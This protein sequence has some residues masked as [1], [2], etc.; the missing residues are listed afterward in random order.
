MRPWDADTGG[1]DG[2]VTDEVHRP[3]VQPGHVSGDSI[4]VSELATTPSPGPRICGEMETVTR[5]AKPAS[6]SNDPRA[7]LGHDGADAFHVDCAVTLQRLYCL[8]VIEAGSRYVHILG[9]TANPDGAW[10]TQQIRNLLTDPGDRAA[11]FR[12]PGPRPGRAVHRG[13]RRSP[14]R[15]R[16]PGRE[17]P[18][19]EPARE[20]LRGTVR[21]HRPDRGH[22]RI[23]IF[24]E[25][26]LPT[27]LAE[28]EAH[29]NGRRPH[30]SRQL[31]PPRP[32]Y[33]AAN[34]SRER[35]KRRP[36]LGGLINEYERA[37]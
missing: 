1:H 26:H 9:V 18:A 8:F 21:A 6:S 12:F 15:C 19:P 13:I 25:R 16:H 35:I 7:S 2:G 17:D 5:P 23:L 14:C 34:V 30:R 11:D 32:N 36:V 27:I 33:P 24:G 4:A 10:T 29:Y 3:V 28:Y 20:P 31:Q 37:A 22:R